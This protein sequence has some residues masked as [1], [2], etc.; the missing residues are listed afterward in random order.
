MEINFIIIAAAALIP[1]V[2]GFLWYNPKLLGTVWM[3][4]T[5]LTEEKMKSANMPLIFGLCYL[6]SFFLALALQGIVIHQWGVFSLVGGNPEAMTS[7]TA[8]ALMAEYG[9][10]FRTFGHGVLHG[11]LTGVFLVFPIFATNGMFERK[12]WK[13]IFINTSYWTITV[14]LMGGV[15]CQWG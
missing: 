4:E 10:H 2:M 9:D 15:I 11:A 1:M 3:K 7:G 13:L 12:S 5:G 8:A 14:S 6:F